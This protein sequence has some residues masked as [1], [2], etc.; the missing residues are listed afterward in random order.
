MNEIYILT[1]SPGEVSGWVRPVVS[2]LSSPGFAAGIFVVV[3]PCQYASGMESRCA[4][5]IVGEKSVCTFRELWKRVSKTAGKKRL[6]LQLGGDPFFGAVL[7]AKM[8]CAWMIYTARPRWKSRV[9][10]YFV[11]DAAAENRFRLHGVAGAR[12]TRVGNLIFDSTPECR[13]KEEARRV[14]G[15][16]EGEEAVSFLPGSRPFEYRSGFAFFAC[17]AMKF[18]RNHPNFHAFLPVAPTV[19]E[20]LIIEGLDE[21]GLSWKGLSAAEEIIWEGPGRIR[22]IR[23]NNFDA[24]RASMLTVAFPGTNNLQIASLGVP[25]LTVI[26]LNQAEEIP[27][28]GIPGMIP[29]N[30]PGARRLK[31]KIVYWY[32]GRLKY[33]SLPNRIAGKEIVPEH[34]GVMTP[35]MVAAFMEDLVS[36]PESLNRI[37]ANY[38]D[39][40]LERGA[41]SRIA[42]KVTDYFSSGGSD[43]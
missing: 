12:V 5:E 4:A 41:A 34:R 29:M 21:A 15:L 22:L 31:K 14:I 43:S 38:S 33:A 2:E 13:D 39:L 3:L 36:D 6:V 18:L 24:I 16:S 25:L 26:P 40:S 19:D 23:E 28:D 20:K 30:L 27:L 35:S 7:S 37:V 10:H 9:T 42:E 1:N 17:A 11:P 32:S 8:G